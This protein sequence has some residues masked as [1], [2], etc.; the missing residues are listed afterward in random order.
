MAGESVAAPVKKNLILTQFF[1][2]FLDF[3]NEWQP[4]VV[5][6]STSFAE[7]NCLCVI[8]FVIRFMAQQSIVFT[9][10]YKT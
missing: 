2:F 3:V 9:F 5:L 1:Q 7:K 8:K 4:H 10:S 6:V